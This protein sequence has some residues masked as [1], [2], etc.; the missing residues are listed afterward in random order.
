MKKIVTKNPVANLI[1]GVL[2]LAAAVLTFVFEDDIVEIL[3]FIFAGI[4]ILYALLRFIKEIKLYKH[5]TARIIVGVELSLVI[6]IAVLLMVTDWLNIA[7][8]LGIVI[9]IRGAIF[10]LIQ[11]VIRRIIPLARF[12]LNLLF[13]T[14]GSYLIFVQPDAVTFFIWFLIVLLAVFALVFIYFSVIQ[15]K[16]KAKQKPKP[17]TE[18]KPVK[19]PVKETPKEEKVTTSKYTKKAL[20]EKSVDDLK[21]MCKKRG[22]TGYSSLRKEALVEKLWLYEHDTN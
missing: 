8:T 16:L 20:M 2:L 12:L 1:I 6:V 18:T 9:Y 4:I 21:A 22:M 7:M 17:V 14:A 5:Q 11:N 19:E 3:K 13:I 10:L 15:F